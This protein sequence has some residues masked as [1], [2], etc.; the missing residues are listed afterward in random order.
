MA[1]LSGGKP[2]RSLPSFFENAFE[3]PVQR[4]VSPSF[5]LKNNRRIALWASGVALIKEFPSYRKSLST[6]DAAIKEHTPDLIINFLEPLMGV[7]NLLRRPTTPTLSVGHQFM[8]QYPG[9]L[10]VRKYASQRLGLKAYI[11]IAGWR[12]TKLAISFYPTPDVPGKRII[13]CPPILRRRLFDLAPH[14]GDR[15]LVYIAFHGFAKDILEWHRLHPEIPIDCFYD[16][17]GAPTEE[18]VSENLIF[19][20]L[21]GEKFLKL[22]AECRAVVST[23]GVESV[24]EA[25]YLGKRLLM[26]PVENH[27]EQFINSKDAERNGLGIADENFALSRVIDPQFK[28]AGANFRAWVD[29][30]EPTVLRAIAE[31]AELRSYADPEEAAM[32]RAFPEALD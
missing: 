21:D 6:I 20:R 18:R 4:I 3:A 32:A 5:V 13:V 28:P 25:A 30:A 16:K 22:M 17:P 10:H 1:V 2:S 9:F 12:S 23:A 7:F 24:S 14:A 11:A 31:A 27:L 15:V 29:R 26:V 8:L 19:H